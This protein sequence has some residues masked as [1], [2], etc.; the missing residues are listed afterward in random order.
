MG[1]AGSLVKPVSRL[2]QAKGMKGDTRIAR[3]VGTDENDY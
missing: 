1:V 3:I 2:G